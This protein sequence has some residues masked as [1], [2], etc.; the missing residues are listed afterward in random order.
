MDSKN[1]TYILLAVI[2]LGAVLRF[3]NLGDNP[4]WIDEAIFAVW[5]NELKLIQEYPTILI[6]H[7]FNF[8]SEYW[9]RFM[10]ALSGTL[11]IPAI[12]LV[13]KNH[14][15]EAAVIVAIFPL[16][17]FWS[18]TARPY[19]FAGLFMVLG[20]RWWYFSIMSIMTN[21]ISLAGVKFKGKK[22]WM[23]AVIGMFVVYSFMNKE[24]TQLSFYALSNYSRLYYLPLLALLLYVTEYNFNYKIFRVFNVKLALF[25]MII[26][27][28]L[29]F[30]PASDYREWYS[31]EVG[32]SDWRNTEKYDFT[33]NQF[34]S[35][36]Y[37]GGKSLDLKDK[38]M[39]LLNQ[40][41]SEGKQIRIGLDYRVLQSSYS[42]YFNQ[43][44]L[45][46]IKPR[47]LKGEIISITLLNVKTN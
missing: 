12:Y 9:L 13:A 47:L 36:W 46:S 18:R 29:A 4:L 14:K 42:E 26:I 32:Y 2:F 22:K 37:S 24:N 33:T 44:Y 3:V 6:A 7:L 27:I 19:A 10:F 21:V 38:F 8:E 5:S 11:T 40:I 28:S 31:S 1:E 43:D 17:V 41:L 39:P 45:E 15:L 23:L 34:P 35:N 30:I 25:T 20:W 16:F